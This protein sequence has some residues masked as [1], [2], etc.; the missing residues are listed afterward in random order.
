MRQLDGNIIGMAIGGRLNFSTFYYFSAYVALF[1]KF[2]REPSFIYVVS[3]ATEDT[4][5]VLSIYHSDG[6]RRQIKEVN[7]LKRPKW[8]LYMYINKLVIR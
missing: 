5:D 2:R 8:K 7:K 1:P 6:S 4:R 3:K